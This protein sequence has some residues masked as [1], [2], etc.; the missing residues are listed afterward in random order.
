MKKIS[1]LTCTNPFHKRH[2][3]DWGFNGILK[4]RKGILRNWCLLCFHEFVVR[5][6]AFFNNKRDERD[7][8][9]PTLLSHSIISEFRIF[10]CRLI[11]S[12]KKKY[13]TMEDISWAVCFCS[14]TNYSRSL[15]RYLCFFKCPIVWCLQVFLGA[16]QGRVR[17]FKVRL[18][19]RLWKG[20]SQDKSCQRSHDGKGYM[21]MY[22][23]VPQQST[24]NYHN[25]VNW[26]Y[27]HKKIKS[28]FF[29]K[30]CHSQ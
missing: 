25:I 5:S 11:S 30:R 28:F 27:S 13:K 22:G 29:F 3:L 12:N 2:V 1:I 24:W 21:Y 26:L 14:W 15:F 9:I 8:V 19:K 20:K 10:Q 17:V 6:E 23:W 7:E 18:W 4:N 16:V